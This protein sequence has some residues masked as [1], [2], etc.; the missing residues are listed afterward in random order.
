[1][2]YIKLKNIIFYGKQGIPWNEV[3]KYIKMY[4][5]SQIIV[6]EY[7]DRIVIN[8]KS[9]DEYTESKYTK[10]LRGA[11][12][13]VNANVVQ[14]LPELI[15]YATNRRWVE[16]KAEK[17]SGDA[18]DGW[19]RYDTYFS[20]PVK[21]ENEESTRWNDYRG[22]LVVKINHRGM[23]FYDLIDIKKEARTPQES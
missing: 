14:I 17:H 2:K 9:A 15:T 18:V 20:I 7:Q 22:T 11:L 23:F 4:S 19:Y 3:E 6:Q 16:N 1:M 8:S 13:K 10:K 5:G 12:A 21:A